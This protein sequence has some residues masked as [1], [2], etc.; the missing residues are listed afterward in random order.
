MSSTRTVRILTTND[1]WAT[2]TQIPTSYGSLP[3]GEGLKYTVEQLRVGQPTIWADVGDVTPGSPLGPV[4][5]GVMGYV[6]AAELGIDV[7]TLGNH[8]FDYGVPHL[9]R[10]APVLGYPVIC[11][12]ADLGFASSHII[13]TSAGPIGFIGITCPQLE[14]F[15]VFAQVPN[16]TLPAP[17]RDVTTAVTTAVASLRQAGVVAIVA[18]IHDGVDWVPQES[19]G[20]AMSSARFAEVCRPWCNQVDVILGGHTLGRFFGDIDGTPVVQPWA[21]SAEVGV[22]D[23]EIGG[24]HGKP[25]GVEVIARGP[26]TGTGRSL[27]AAA[28]AQ[29]LGSLPE[30]L[31]AYPGPNQP[32]TQFLATAFQRATDADVALGA[33]FQSQFPLDNKI[34]AL[35]AGPLPAYMLPRLLP[36]ANGTLVQGEVSREELASA[37]TTLPTMPYWKPHFAWDFVPRANTLPATVKL[38]TTGGYMTLALDGLVGRSIDWYTTP[39]TARDAV[40]ELLRKG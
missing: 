11:A 2:Y 12:N 26:W 10:Y 16:L 9:Q 5:D 17:N 40:A 32:L 24:T 33:I 8:E 7:G 38:V 14:L 4:S 18:M 39:V 29:V 27:I 36:I 30:P 35:H 3:G 37:E 20:L 23:L 21:Y 22:I 19:D 13:E 31:E 15:G 1:F 6:A 28:E 34:A 25:Y